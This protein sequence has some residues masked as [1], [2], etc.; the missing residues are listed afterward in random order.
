[1]KRFVNMGVL[2]LV[3]CVAQP[4]V[5]GDVCQEAAAHL[6]TCR[7]VPQTGNAGVCDEAEAMALLETPCEELGESK[8]W[9]LCDLI[10]IFC[11]PPQDRNL[12]DLMSTAWV[13]DM[14]CVLR[15]EDTI[16]NGDETA[17]V[18]GMALKAELTCNDVLDAKYT[19]WDDGGLSEI[20][21]ADPIRNLV[22]GC[23]GWSVKRGDDDQIE[24][25]VLDGINGCPRFR[26]PVSDR[27]SGPNRLLG[28]TFAGTVSWT[29]EDEP[30]LDS[31]ELEFAPE[32][33]GGAV[34]GVV[35]CP[36]AD[37]VFLGM[38]RFERAMTFASG[39]AV[40]VGDHPGE[41][42]LDGGQL[43][44]TSE[45]EGLTFELQRQPPSSDVGM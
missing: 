26:L 35:S 18:S 25:I 9:S 6:S 32:L 43:S 31:C 4:G 41:Y 28:S 2:T 42:R 15:F 39:G 23:D 24:E 13:D 36:Y 14:A 44:I 7:G 16:A 3:G 21:F 33:D 27:V 40:R 1:M 19:F 45:A 29:N 5:S 12:V 11:D 10:G 34:R 22:E 17:A 37:S 38:S 30:P 8:S 20:F